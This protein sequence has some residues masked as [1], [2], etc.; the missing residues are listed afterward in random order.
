MSVLLAAVPSSASYI[1]NSYGFSGGA[2]NGGSATYKINGSA[3]VAGGVLGSATYKLPA[4]IKAS[5]TAPT[6]GAPA[7][8]NPANNYD[9]LKLVLNVSTFPSDTKYLIAISTDGFATT[10]YVQTDNTVGAALSISNYQTYAAWGGASGVTIVGLTSGTTYTVKVA[11]LQ[12]SGTGSGFGPTATAAT[13]APSVTFGVTTSLTSTPPFTTTFAS[14]TPGAVVSGNATIIA[15]ITTNALN[16]GGLDVQSQFGGLKSTLASYTLP[17]ATADLSAA[18][19]GYGARV[20]AATQSSGGPVAA[21]SPYNGSSNNVGSLSTA[22]QPL[23]TFPTAITGAN[24]TTT[25][26]A[27]TDISVPSASDY[28]DTITLSLSLLF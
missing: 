19:K 22:L 14:L 28:S 9:R 12:G 25:L 13:V 26:M 10:N 11:A 5:T 20:T 8:T 15:A 2:N 16:G 7:F 18:G 23:A 4:G 6:P 17:S 27:K 1:L 21:T 24:I 3:G